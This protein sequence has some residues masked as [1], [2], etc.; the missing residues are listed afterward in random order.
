MKI[1]WLKIIGVV[2][3]VCI[4]AFLCYGAYRFYFSPPKPVINNYTVQ[5]GGTINQQKLKQKN[6]AVGVFGTNDKTF[7][8]HFS[9][10]F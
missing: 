6:F 9:V 3:M 4:V 10:L 1:D 5:S 2:A 8:V 7:G